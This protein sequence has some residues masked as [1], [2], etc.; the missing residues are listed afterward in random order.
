[1]SIGIGGAGARPG[2]DGLSCTAF[3]S[4]VGAIPVEVTEAASPLI[5]HRREL[6]PDS[7]G[8]GLYRGGLGA[9]IEIGHRYEEAF[10]VSA[11]TFDRREYPARGRSGGSD[12]RAGSSRR[13][14]GTALTGKG[15]YEI[16]AGQR[17]IIELPGGGGWGNPA[18]RAPH[19][20]AD[21][22]AWGLV[23]SQ[24]AQSCY[25]SDRRNA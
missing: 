18:N 11:A 14:D 12:G 17:L 5:F 15:V 9:I 2:K 23:S 6:L 10:R 21:E 22:V 1:M 16:P 25:G 7:G 3:P 13:S 24:S 19:T 8:A 20:L 4:G